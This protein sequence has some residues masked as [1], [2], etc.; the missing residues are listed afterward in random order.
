M[1]FPLTLFK[2]HKKKLQKDTSFHRKK[3]LA[4]LAILLKY[5]DILMKRYWDK[6]IIWYFF[7]EKYQFLDNSVSHLPVKAYS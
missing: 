1:F 2:L 7:I 6:I 3:G 4:R 5:Y